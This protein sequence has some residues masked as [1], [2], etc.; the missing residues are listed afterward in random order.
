MTLNV[1]WRIQDGVG[2]RVAEATMGWWAV[3]LPRKK[4]HFF[5]SKLCIMLNFHFIH[6]DFLLAPAVQAV[7]RHA[8]AEP[9]F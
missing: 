9:R 1:E 5:L 2:S 8:W 6:G 3:P 4:M 7:T